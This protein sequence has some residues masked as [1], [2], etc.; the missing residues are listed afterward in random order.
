MLFLQCILQQSEKR[1]SNTKCPTRSNTYIEKTLP[2]YAVKPTS[3]KKTNIPINFSEPAASIAT[4]LI[5]GR[6]GGEKN[7]KC[8]D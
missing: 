3:V 7:W 5:G 4:V 6:T 2:K 1:K 8:Y